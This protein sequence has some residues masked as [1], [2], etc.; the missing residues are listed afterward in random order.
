MLSDYWTDA[1][2]E[3]EL[4]LARGGGY[5]LLEFVTGKTE[6]PR[7]LPVDQPVSEIVFVPLYYVSAKSY[8]FFG[9]GNETIM[10][11]SSLSEERA[12]AINENKERP[13]EIPTA[14]RAAPP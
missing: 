4:I 14:L 5:G 7:N 6:L 8:M 3:K 13:L 1:I 10:F 9:Y 12:T 2:A 11:D